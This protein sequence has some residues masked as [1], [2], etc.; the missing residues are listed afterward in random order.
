MGL[1]LL[2]ISDIHFRQYRNFQ[3]LDLDKDIQAEIEFDLK[4][5]KGEYGKIDI[6]LI[7]GD[8]AFSGKIEEYDY[9]QEWIEKICGIT[10]CQKENV[11]TVPGN[12]DIE[13]S[14]VKGMLK[15]AHVTFKALSDRKG[16]D[17]MLTDYIVDQDSANALI[18]P[19]N[20]YKNFALKYGSIPRED[21]ILYWEKDF[22]FDRSILRIRGLNSALIS[23]D[24][25]N[26]TDSKLILGS[27]QTNIIRE[28]GYINIVLCH[29]PP[30]WILDGEQ[31]KKDL[32]ARARIHL[33]GH[34]HAFETEL[35]DNNNI[36]LSA[37]AMQPSRS[38]TDWEPR[39]NILELNQ[40]EKDKSY[41]LN[42]KLFKRVWKKQS[43][44]FGTDFTENGEKFQELNIALDPT[45]ILDEPSVSHAVNADKINLNP[46]ADSVIDVNNPNPKRK[47]FYM[48]V[49][50]PYHVKLQIAVS[51]KLVEDSDENL[52][53]VKKTEQYFKRA[54][55]KKLLHQL[56][57]QVTNA[58]GEKLTNPF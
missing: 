31:A 39:Y 30:D 12:H 32:K 33:Y 13:R 43:K 37:G 20:N 10:E 11:L 44:K 47:L 49:S 34:K 7:G 14:K 16:I 15:T 6:I 55:D 1:K 52:S 35:L 19:L 56:W 40:F 51:L 36:V 24:T 22:A 5:L 38:E 57:N 8:I 23:D 21:N 28:Q 25:D 3:F 9:A 26:T 58:S 41:F 2:H 54:I 29:H 53:V 48:F 42:V 27:A 45:E 46:M 50:L 18:S 17:R 4:Q